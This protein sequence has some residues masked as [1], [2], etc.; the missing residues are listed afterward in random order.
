MLLCGL[1]L[2]SLGAGGLLVLSHM[3][4]FIICGILLGVTLKMCAAMV[5]IVDPQLASR[6]SEHVHGSTLPILVFSPQN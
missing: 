3:A 2:V 5:A 1:S 6:R 4:P